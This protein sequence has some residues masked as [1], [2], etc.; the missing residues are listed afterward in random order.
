M[1]NVA[2]EKGEKLTPSSAG[3][4]IDAHM[5]TW[6]VIDTKTHDGKRVYLLE[7]EQRGDEAS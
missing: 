1:E 2:Y 7:H 3:I 5:G 6:H 4:K